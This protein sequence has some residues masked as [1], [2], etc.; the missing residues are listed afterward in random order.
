MRKRSWSWLARVLVTA[1]LPVTGAVAQNGTT[2][3]DEEE[4]YIRRNMALIEFSRLGVS[5]KQYVKTVKSVNVQDPE[6]TLKTVQ[7][8]KEEFRDDGQ[9][10][11]Q[12][13]ND[14]VLTCTVAEQYQNGEAII[15]PGSYQAA[16][17]EVIVHDESFDQAL[18]GRFP[19][20]PHISVTCKFRWKRCNEFPYPANQVCMNMGPPYGTLIFYDCQL[21]ISW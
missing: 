11:D 12:A 13:A 6:K 5:Q 9:G 17:E 10:Y 14:G 4:S 15:P 8:G 19:W 21:G 3:V 18:A 16:R 2:D 20:L 1:A 7:M